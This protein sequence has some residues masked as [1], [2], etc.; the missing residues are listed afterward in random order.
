MAGITAAFHGGQCTKA[1]DEHP[2]RD[3]TVQTLTLF[4]A[5]APSTAGRVLLPSLGL[6]KCCRAQSLQWSQA[7]GY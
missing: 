4:L 1:P 2:T 3:S 5:Q 6:K 7:Q